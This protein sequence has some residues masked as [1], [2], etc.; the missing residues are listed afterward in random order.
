M[1]NANAP[2]IVQPAPQPTPEKHI[3]IFSSP[4]QTSTP[5]ESVKHEFIKSLISKLPKIASHTHFNS[6]HARLLPSITPKHPSSNSATEITNSLFFKEF[7]PSKTTF[8]WNSLIEIFTVNY[9]F[10]QSLFLFKKLLLSPFSKP[11]PLTFPPLLKSCVGLLAPKI[12][13]GLHGYLIKCGF[14]NLVAVD[15]SL[16]LMYMKFGRIRDA[17][18][19]FEEMPIRDSVSYNY[20]VCDFGANGFYEDVLMVFERMLKSGFLPNMDSVFHAIMAC[21]ELGSIS[22]GMLIHNFVIRNGFASYVAIANLLISMHLKFERLDLGRQVFN[23][24]SERDVVSWNSMITGYARSG[25]WVQAFG[26]FLSMKKEGHLVPSRVTFL[27]LVLACGQAGNLDFGK[28]IHG[29][30]IRIGLLSDFRLGTSIVDMYSKCG[31]VEDAGIIFEEELFERSLVSWNSLIAGYS[32]NGYDYEAVKLFKRMLLESNLKPDAITFAN[33]IPAFASL[34]NLHMIRSIHALILKKGIKLDDDIV[35]STA[36]VDAYGKCLDIEAATSL[37]TCIGKPN[38]ATF[39]AM[40]SGYNLNQLAHHAMM[41]FLEML[42]SNVLPD[43]ITVVMLLQSC[44]EL[45]SLKQGSMAHGYCLSKGFSSHLTVGNAMIDMYMRCGCTKSSLLLFSS[46]SLKNVVTWNTMLFGY[47]KIGHSV[48]ALK[49][50][51]KMQSENQYKLDSVTIISV[52]QACAVVSARHNGE[53][54]HGLTLKLGFD[55]E[56]LAMNSLVDAYAKNGLIDNAR[57]LFKQMGESRDQ[58]SWN[59][60]IAGC[61]MNGKGEEACMLLS[62]MEEDGFKPNSITFTSLLAS[63][64]H[65]GLVDEACRY[66]DMMVKKYK[67]HPSLEHWTCMIDM[68]GRAGRLEEAYQLI[69]SGLPENSGC[70]VLSD[71]DAVWGA[72][73]SACRTDMNMELGK[74]AGER[75]LRLAPD[76]CGYYT[77]LS[78]LYASGKR[79]DEAAKVRRVSEDGGLMK[80]PGLSIVK[81]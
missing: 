43:S 53:I 17:V 47:V 3:P 74:L 57:S 70:L 48:M 44:G 13:F 69:K 80:K 1:Q 65:S 56:T 10:L 9:R 23:E 73:L 8:S 5:K 22:R 63:C 25:D 62:R 41:L 2:L 31:R 18:Q 37:F 66:F 76:N 24:I 54:V 33:V 51:S 42:R 12:G 59:V 67:I 28:S 21:C 40:I 29:R 19:L 46:M 4:A 36:M 27:G 35:L 79:W 15:S 45:E 7:L 26:L 64:S 75:L 52:I 58:S 11:D 71:C 6:F 81:M 20:L 49:M 72:L 61:G 68:F 14:R 78:N 77:L 50:F 60:M 32:Q 39:N 16:V 30:L 38:V 34:A 55:S